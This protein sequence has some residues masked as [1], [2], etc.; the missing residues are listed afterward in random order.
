MRTRAAWAVVIFALV[1]GP[2]LGRDEPGSGGSGG[3]DPPPPPPVVTNVQVI[4][5]STLYASG[6]I[7]AR[8]DRYISD[9]TAQGYT[10]TLVT[11]KFSTPAQLRTHISTSYSQPGGLAGVVLVGDLPISRYEVAAHDTWSA[12]NFPCDLYYQ[13]VDGVW[14]DA[15]ADNRFDTHTGNVAPEI[16]VG[17]LLTHRLTGLHEGRTEASLLNDYF[18]KNHAYRTGQLGIADDA[19]LYIDDD[20]KNSASSWASGVA[21]GV[22]GQVT[23]VT[24]NTTAANFKLAVRKQYEHLLLAAHSNSSNNQFKIGTSWSG[25]YVY[26]HELEALDP[27]VLFYNL[28]ACSNCNFG[29][30]GY[31]G[32]EYVFGTSKGLLAV[33]SSKTGSMLGFNNYYYHLGQGDVFG[34]ALLKWWNVQASGGFSQYEIDWY[35]GM[36]IIGDPMLV[37]QQHVVPE[38]ATLVLLAVGVVGLVRRRR[39]ALRAC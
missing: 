10:P 20:W 38:P 11:T 27:Q 33:G 5:N 35:Y 13:D 9:I 15:D 18:D 19:L 1:A 30:T 21:Y 32:G 25:G 14:G 34:D 26:N 31:M 17:R 24:D 22:S 6:Q 8:L 36:N 3:G 12:E 7:N 16:W 23:V 2:A 28:F 37:T 39:A 29:N 4:V